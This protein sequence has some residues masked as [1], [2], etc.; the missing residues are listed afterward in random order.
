MN[1]ELPKTAM[2]T[3]TK[4]SIN[5]TFRLF[6]AF[7][8]G[9]VL[10]FNAQFLTNNKENVATAFLRGTAEGDETLDHH[11]H[12][13]SFEGTNT[14]ISELQADLSK[15]HS[16]I[17]T[18][19]QQFIASTDNSVDNLKSFP[20]ELYSLGNSLIGAVN[21]QRA[22]AEAHEIVEVSVLNE[23]ILMTSHRNDDSIPR[24]K[25]EFTNGGGYKFGEKLRDAP[26]ETPP[27]IL[28]VGGNLGFSSIAYAKFYDNAQIIVF[29]PNP[30]TYIYLRWNLFLNNIHVLSAEELEL[31]PASSGVYPVFGGLAG[32]AKPYITVAMPS[33]FPEKSQNNVLSGANSEGT[34]ENGSM[35][36]P[37]YSLSKFL[38]HHSLTERNIDIA[39]VDCECCEYMLIAENKELFGSREK[40]K[41][42]V[43]EL[44]PFEICMQ[45]FNLT[46]EAQEKVVEAFKNRDCAIKPE[47]F[48]RQFV[49]YKGSNNAKCCPVMC[50]DD[51]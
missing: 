7:L 38:E 48:D 32:G 46:M 42:V 36:V 6:F 4:N 33:N 16:E 3:A 35:G 40:V 44:H 29:E 26:T 30:F 37:V 5:A 10:A 18:L 41:S 17:A 8:A 2:A 28:D 1:I 20:R 21:T 34:N 49:G 14:K 23:K 19:L 47:E 11:L 12:G 50:A 31:H 27:L 15:Q 51:G 9:Y 45:Y 39:K 25:L 13:I 24:L 22:I 43:G